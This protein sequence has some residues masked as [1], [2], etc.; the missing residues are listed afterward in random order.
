[1]SV[2]RQTA[3]RRAEQ[4]LREGRHALAIEEYLRVLEAQPRDW[5]TANALGDLYVRDNQQ[6]RA[7][8]QF[9]RSADGLFADG[10]VTRAAALYR[11]ALQFD[12][13]NEHALARLVEA[14]ST[15]GVI[16]ANPHAIHLDDVGTVADVPLE[17][18]DVDVPSEA[19]APALEDV[20]AVFREEAAMET[21]GGATQAALARGLALQAAGEIDASLPDLER[22]ARAP[23][24]RFEAASCLAR[25]YRDRGQFREAV[26][27]FERAAEAPAPTESE[28][29]R[30]LY[31]LAGTLESA[32]EAERALA[33]YLELRIAAGPYL[34]V[35]ERVRRLAS[36][37]SRG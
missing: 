7:V 25:T 14:A 1:V 29:H 37:G 15:R 23:Q 24:L 20:F 19:S 8:E 18:V 5:S 17:V 16:T 34:D 27:W 30:V 12:P 9:V 13:V 2:D 31:E 22:A 33:V 3:L 32:G 26:E 11:K 6:V 35:A 4:L 10:F 36:A 21:S 28:G